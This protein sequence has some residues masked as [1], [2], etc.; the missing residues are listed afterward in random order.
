MTYTVKRLT[1]NDI[2]PALLTYICDRVDKAKETY[3]LDVNYKENFWLSDAI[4]NHLVTVCYKDGEP[5]GIMFG[6]IEQMIFDNSKKI[7]RQQLLLSDHPRATVALIR[8]F[9]DFGQSHANYVLMCR[10]KYTNVKPE[11]FK[12]FGFEKLEEWYALEA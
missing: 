11:S 4:K 12:K 5:I 3:G 7:L 8:Y 6:T 2:T 1:I 10:G 9:I